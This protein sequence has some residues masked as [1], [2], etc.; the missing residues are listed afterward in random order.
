MSFYV[1]PIKVHATVFGG[2]LIYS[3]CVMLLQGVYKVVE[4]CFQCMLYEK[5]VYHQC[6]NYIIV[7]MLEQTWCSPCFVVSGVGEDGNEVIM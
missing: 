7:V 4:C 5:V 6:E 1:V 3:Y 2:L